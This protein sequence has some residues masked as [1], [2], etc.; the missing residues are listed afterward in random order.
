MS[1]LGNGWKSFNTFTPCYIWHW[2]LPGWITDDSIGRQIP[3]LI[4]I[5]LGFPSGSH[6]WS[7]NSKSIPFPFNGMT[8]PWC[9]N[10]RSSPRYLA[11]VWLWVTP[12]NFLIKSFFLSF[13]I[14]KSHLKMGWSSSSISGMVNNY[15]GKIKIVSSGGYKTFEIFHVGKSLY[16]PN[17]YYDNY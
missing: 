9:W 8:P 12:I 16:T 11:K 10:L 14:R 5:F 3:L 7:I 17:G 1:I 15:S 6:W 2:H 13:K 4:G